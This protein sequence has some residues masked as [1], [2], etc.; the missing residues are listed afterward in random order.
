M[1]K[2]T[3]AINDTMK[4]DVKMLMN[5]IPE[6]SMLCS[7]AMTIQMIKKKRKLHLLANWGVQK[8]VACKPRT[9]L[10][11]CTAGKRAHLTDNT[12]FDYLA[13]LKRSFDKGELDNGE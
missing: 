12:N 10:S 13:I 6:L 8:A 4:V 7:W 1:A 11:N 3:G 9:V 5:L 2:V